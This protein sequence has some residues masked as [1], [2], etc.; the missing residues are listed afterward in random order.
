MCVCRLIDAEKEV[1]HRG[2]RVVR[3]AGLYSNNR[4]PHSYWMKLAE[5]G[6]V[7]ESNSDGIVN[8]V[9]YEDAARAMIAALEAGNVYCA[10]TILFC[11]LFSHL[12]PLGHPSEHEQQAY[13]AVDKCPLTKLQ[14]C[15]I[16]LE[17]QQFANMDLPKVNHPI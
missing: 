12:I 3:L 9:H 13:I 6:K 15:K 14:I 5:E 2:G 4:G 16:A 17:S 11:N 8:L 10:I 1:F 7:I